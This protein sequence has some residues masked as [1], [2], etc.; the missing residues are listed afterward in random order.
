MTDQWKLIPFSVNFFPTTAWKWRIFG[1]EE[2]SL[3]PP[4]PPAASLHCLFLTYVLRKYF[5]WFLNMLA[6]SYKWCYKMTW[7]LRTKVVNIRQWKFHQ[8]AHWTRGLKGKQVK[9]CKGASPC[10][11]APLDPSTLVP[12][13]P[14]SL[15][16]LCHFAFPSCTCLPS[17]PCTFHHC[18]QPS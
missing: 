10:A 4:P 11:H 17:C 8:V 2:A 9:R 5:M 6:Y 16:P 13:C 12:S 15:P 18:T 14:F 7:A 3:A 1:W